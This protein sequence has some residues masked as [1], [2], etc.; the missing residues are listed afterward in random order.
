MNCVANLLNRCVEER[1]NLGELELSRL[2]VG[3]FGTYL[4]ANVVRYL[5]VNVN[6]KLMFFGNLFLLHDLYKII[7][8]II[9]FNFAAINSFVR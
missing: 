7:I 8:K 5:E 9:D 6:F 3:L 2:H 1:A 4:L